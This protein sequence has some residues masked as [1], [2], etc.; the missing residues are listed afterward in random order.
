MAE[1]TYRA[2]TAADAGALA[3]VARTALWMRSPFLGRFRAR[4]S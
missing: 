1:V 3:A 2:A 4:R